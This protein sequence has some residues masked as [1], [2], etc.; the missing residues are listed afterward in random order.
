MENKSEFN[1]LL[2]NIACSAMACDSDIDERE[3][4]E[5]IDISNSTTYF[6][7]INISENL[8]KFKEKFN[9]NPEKTIANN[10]RKLKTI[11]LDF[12]KELL[13][14]EIVLRIIY[15]DTKIDPHE[16][17]F[18]KKVR[19]ML[20]ISDNIIKE[21]FGEINFLFNQEFIVR[22]KE[23]IQKEKLSHNEMLNI[24]NMYLEN[25]NKK[26]TPNKGPNN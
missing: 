22:Q 20:T 13:V 21:R 14:L 12:V 4:K 19:G 3:E 10:I 5:I 16:I 7:G 17:E 8:G 26:S 23:G 9:E 24:E 25:D 11:E 2:F 6:E 18:V 1:S 15:A